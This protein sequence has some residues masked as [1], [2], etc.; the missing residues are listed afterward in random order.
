M[1]D[2]LR[3]TLATPAKVIPLRVSDAPPPAPN[4][5]ASKEAVLAWAEQNL[6]A[7]QRLIARLKAELAQL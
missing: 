3:L 4:A 1:S 6:V 2:Q 7:T 5:R